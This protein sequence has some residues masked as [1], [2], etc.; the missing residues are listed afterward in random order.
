MFVPAINALFNEV[1]KP[2]RLQV[3]PFGSPRSTLDGRNH[4][5]AEQDQ[6]ATFIFANSHAFKVRRTPSFFAA[7][8]NCLSKVASSASLR[9]ANS[10]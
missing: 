5:Q 1:L 6:I 8:A 3:E 10:R 7:L 4:Q 9:I 2:I